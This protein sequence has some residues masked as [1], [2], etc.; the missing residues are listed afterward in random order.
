[1]NDDPSNAFAFI[2]GAGGSAAVMYLWIRNLLEQVKTLQEEVKNERH[3]NDEFGQSIIAIASE[4]K[5]HLAGA[6]RNCEDVKEHVTGE[7]EK[8]RTEIRIRKDETQE[9]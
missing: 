2:T 5:I 8:T 4:T 7:H 1:M 6:S 3:R 9:R